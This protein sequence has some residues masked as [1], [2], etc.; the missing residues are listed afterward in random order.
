M[1]TYQE[2]M[3]DLVSLCKNPIPE[4]RVKELMEYGPVRLSLDGNCGCA[5]MGQNLQEGEAE[6]FEVNYEEINDSRINAERRAVVRAFNR[7]KARCGGDS[8]RYYTGDCQ[9]LF[10]A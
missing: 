7:L 2:Y 5:L 6:F 1:L 10:G 9:G 4:N 8:L 3:D